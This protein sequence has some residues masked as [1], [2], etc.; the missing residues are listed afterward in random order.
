MATGYEEDIDVPTEPIGDLGDG[1]AV[2]ADD[3]APGV[4]VS[5]TFRRS[6]TFA[7]FAAALAKAQGAME[8]A[9]KDN[10]NPHFKSKYADLASVWEACR[11][12]LSDNGIAVLQPPCAK[13]S[14]VTVT[15]LLAH[16]SGE[17]I[18]S[19]LTMAAQQNTPQA[20][21]SCITYAR[22]YALASMVGVAPEDDDAEAAQG[23]SNGNG[24][25]QQ[26]PPAPRPQPITSTPDGF[27]AWLLDMEAT[28]IEGT[29]ALEAAWKKSQPY[30][31]KY[32]TDTDNA[33]WERLKAKA[34]Q[35]KVSA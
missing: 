5:M 28:A 8:G 3:A 1:P 21:G 29:A 20:I 15:T 22:R 23:R 27:D 11:G 12:P 34:A 35:V 18:Q 24:Q 9:S 30:M 19:D 14:V 10:V 33:K 16:A 2:P 31:R 26:R 13:G 7:A 25:Q 6:S 4:F 17:W 32:L